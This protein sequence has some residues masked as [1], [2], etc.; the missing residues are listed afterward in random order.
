MDTI[1]KSKVFGFDDYYQNDFDAAKCKAFGASFVSHKAGQGT[2]SYG[3]GTD[4]AFKDRIKATR[5]VGLVDN[6]YW[7]FDSRCS[8]QQQADLF[9]E[10]MGGNWGAIPPCV[11]AETP[12]G[13]LTP[14]EYWATPHS[15]RSSLAGFIAD[16]ET[17]TKTKM[18]VYSSPSFLG[19]ILSGASVAE[20]AWWTDRPLWIA[21]YAP[22]PKP[23]FW[24]SWIFWQ[25]SE[26][27]DGGDNGQVDLN[28]FNGDM[29]AF[30]AAYAVATPATPPP[31]VVI[32]PAPALSVKSFSFDASIG[33]LVVLMS[34]GTTRSLP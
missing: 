17:V 9:I 13:K 26:A 28:Y 23:P 4:P 27:A 15:G 34:D 18:V 12:Y 7:L 20:L 32:E 25:S 22:Q 3:L 21:Q 11:D 31:L 1:D 33:K 6:A 19:M 30:Q 16:V 29:A 14:A 2:P 5:D 10:Q 24:P 8:V